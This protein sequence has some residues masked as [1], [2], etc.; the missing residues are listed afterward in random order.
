MANS[1]MDIQLEKIRLIEALIKVEDVSLIEEI[2]SLM[3][4]QT[5]PTVGFDI[6]GESISKSQL[7]SQIEEAE[8]RVDSGVF[9]SQESLEQESENW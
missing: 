4:N 8:D 6:N 9:V 2:K 5:D 1:F 7:I 3:E